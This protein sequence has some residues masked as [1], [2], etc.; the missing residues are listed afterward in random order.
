MQQS[1]IINAIDVGSSKI[2]VLVGQYFPSEDKT[3]IV[4]VVSENAL[5]F[6]KGQIINLEQAIDTLTKS[7]ESAE[8]MAGM[9]INSAHVSISAPHIESINSQGVVAISHP[10]N[11]ITTTDVD[12]AI[13]AAQ[14][15]TLPAGKEIM[16]VIPRKFM[17]DGQDG[18]VDPINM[19][20]IRLEVETHII[21]GST[22][23]IKNLKRCL[24]Q[25]GI[26]PQ[27]LNYS[28]IPTALTSLTDTEKELGVALVDIGGQ[29]T[30]LTIFD[31][32]SPAYSSVI[33]VGGNNITNDL[34]IGLRLSIEEAEKLKI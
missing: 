23:A 30:T 13:E 3:N 22:P 19:T 8:R 7:I 28:G 6:R 14:A 5:G 24:D 1:K 33:P 11:E 29:T 4:A 20:G 21:F 17:V 18:I 12:R 26:K 34:A 16:H 9:S 2:T 25:I 10:Q 32:T 15:V 31:Q 27:T